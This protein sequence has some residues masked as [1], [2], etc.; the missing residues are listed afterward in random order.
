MS[1]RRF[2]S[3]GLLVIFTCTATTAPATAQEKPLLAWKFEAGKSF[4]LERSFETKQTMQVMGMDVSQIQSH[5]LVTRW[6]PKELRNDHW[7]IVVRIQRYKG[8][9]LLGGNRFDFDS[10]KGPG[11]LEGGEFVLTVDPSYRVSKIDG[12]AALVKQAKEGNPDH[13]EAVYLLSLL[14]EDYLRQQA[15]E[16]LEWLPGEKK[17]GGAGEGWLRQGDIRLGGFGSYELTRKSNYHG[18]QGQWDRINVLTALKVRPAKNLF[19]MQPPNFTK[20]EGSGVVLF[21]RIS[22]RVVHIEEELHLEGEVV[23]DIAGQQTPFKL[24]E[25]QRMVVKITDKKPQ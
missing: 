6:T 8:D 14:K 3:I 1:S 16:T 11:G 4:Y 17:A 2:R 18:K 5:T 23:R 25:K 24:K 19:P 15:R 22:G 9:F 10:A 20:A 12:V 7:V 13:W 21:D